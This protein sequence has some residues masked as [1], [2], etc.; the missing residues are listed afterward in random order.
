MRKSPSGSYPGGVNGAKPTAAKPPYVMT[1]LTPS[2]GTVTFSSEGQEGGKYHSRKLHVPGDTSGLTLGRGYDMKMRNK[3]QIISDLVRAGVDKEKAT[4]IAGGAH[5]EGK[6][7]REY[8]KKNN[9]ENFEI[10]SLSQIKLF[11]RSY[12][13]EEAEVLRISKKPDVVKAY[14][15]LDW[16]K[17]DPAIKDL[18]VDLKFRGDY[19]GHTRALVQK[20]AAEN[21][22][23]ELAKLMANR[24]KWKNVPDD[25]FKRRKE[26]LEN[27]ATPKRPGPV[28]FASE[29][30]GLPTS[31]RNILP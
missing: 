7:A 9:L 30:P 5:L 18:L 13:H 23:T 15:A 14:G 12:D 21:N 4:L 24:E 11:E 26:F 29:I 6:K 17:T 20:L 28:P 25:R 27:A 2:R 1:S 10:N 16:K 3:N 22:L 19:T 8:I 31:G